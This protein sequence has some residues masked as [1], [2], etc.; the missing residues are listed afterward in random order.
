MSAKKLFTGAIAAVALS[1]AS[2]S[3]ATTVVT[4][5]PSAPNGLGAAGVLGTSTGFTATGGTLELGKI[6]TPAVLSIANNTGITTFSETGRIFL[7][8]FNNVA[9]PSAP[10]VPGTGLLSQYNVYIDFTLTGG[11]QWIASNTFSAAPGSLNFSA[12]MYGDDVGANGPVTLGSMSLLGSATSFALAFTSGSAAVTSS[13]GTAN[14]VFS[15]T[16]GFS[17]QA[18]TTGVGGFFEAPSPFAVDIAVGS[19]GGNNGN[20]NYTVSSTGV[21]TITT[22]TQGSA[23]TG[24]FT[25]VAQ[26][27]EPGALSLVGLALCGV[28]V[29][30]R[31]Q[32]KKTAVA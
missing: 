27:P 28:A 20:T 30:S 6:G 17:P 14:T 18:G 5:N 8:S 1:A 2:M 10:G 21:V 9:F 12:T 24:N 15:A 22:P 16:L 26:V 29:A 4:L 11:G 13:A 3:F 23:S 31:R 7:T 19:I 32:A 25:F